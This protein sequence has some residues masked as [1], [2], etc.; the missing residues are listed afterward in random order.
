LSRFVDDARKSSMEKDG[1]SHRGKER[2][3]ALVEMA[4]VAPMLLLVLFGIVEFGWKFAEFTE[5]RQATREAARYAAT[6]SPD[7]TGDTSFTAADVVESV[8]NALQLATSGR[9]DVTV[10]RVTGGTIG[11]TAQV[12]VAIDTHSLTGAPIISSFLPSTLTN[13]AVFR[14]EQPASWTDSTLNDQC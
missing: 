10:A 7:L 6:S 3:A 11:D 13:S 12:T 5:L 8:C 9:V 2:G 1:M 14:L 4:M